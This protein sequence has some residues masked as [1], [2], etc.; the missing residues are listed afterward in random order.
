MLLMLKSCSLMLKIKHWKWKWWKKDRR[1]T[2]GHIQIN[3]LFLTMKT[4]SK[5]Y[6]ISERIVIVW[7]NLREMKHFIKSNWEEIRIM[8]KKDWT[9]SSW[10]ICSKKSAL[11]GQRHLRQKR[12]SLPSRRAFAL[13]KDGGL[14][15][16]WASQRTLIFLN[17]DLSCLWWYSRETW[18]KKPRTWQI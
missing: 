18:L 2:D 17:W 1:K 16:Q 5:L 14:G 3:K 8:C 15:S 4:S 11:M 9:E 12:V 7:I 13:G 6:T 10:A